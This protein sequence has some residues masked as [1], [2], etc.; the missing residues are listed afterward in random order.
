MGELEEFSE[1]LI[2]QLEIELNEEKTI[3]DLTEKI[4]EDPSFSIKFDSLEEIS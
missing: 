3:K 4:K 1:S 2:A